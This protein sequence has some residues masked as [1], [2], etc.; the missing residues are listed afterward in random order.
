MLEQGNMTVAE[1]S[2]KFTQ[3]SVYALNLVS[4]EEE[5]CQKFEEGLAYDIRNKLTPTDLDNFSKLMAAAIR[6]EKL[7][8]ER[9]SYFANQRES[10]SKRKDR[11]YSGSRDGNNSRYSG[12]RKGGSGSSSQSSQ[13]SNTGQKPLCDTCGKNHFGEC[14][15]KTGGCL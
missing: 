3:L 4:T 12:S 8:K 14:W 10:S 13:R 2:L 9:K 1:Y 15:K 6:A 5:K 11:P 7:V